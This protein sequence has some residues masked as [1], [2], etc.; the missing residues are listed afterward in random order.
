MGGIACLFLWRSFAFFGEVFSGTKIAFFVDATVSQFFLSFQRLHITKF[1]A[2][3]CLHY[4]QWNQPTCFVF[5]LCF[6]QSIIRRSNRHQFFH[7]FEL[8]VEKGHHYH[9]NFHRVF[10]SQHFMCK[11]GGSSFFGYN[12]VYFG[13]QLFSLSGRKP[14]LNNWFLN[15]I[16]CLNKLNYS[17]KRGR[18]ALL[19]FSL[20]FSDT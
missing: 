2:D 7:A 6:V 13:N 16:I 20:I 9:F 3:H 8:N 11:K 15:Y 17:W 18:P 10:A 4:T 1:H 19:E 5:F 12:L 14:T